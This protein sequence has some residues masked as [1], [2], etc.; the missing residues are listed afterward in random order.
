M[1]CGESS[2]LD[3]REQTYPK[4]MD[5]KDIYVSEN[6]GTNAV[7]YQTYV[8]LA[9]MDELLS[10]P[11]IVDEY[12]PYDVYSPRAESIKEG[13]NKYLWMPEKGYY[14]Q[15]LYGRH[16]LSLS[17][18]FEALGEALSVLFEVAEGEKAR[19]IIANSPLTTY[20]ATC[21]YP[22]IPGIPP[23]HNN[24]IWPFVQSYWNLAAAKVGNEQV[25][26]HGLASIYRAGAL[27]LTNYENFV[28][29]NGDHK[30][31]EINSHRMLWSMA[32]NI[33]MVHRVF[34]GMEFE[35]D[36]IRFHPVIPKA[37]TGVRTLSH[38]AY[39]QSDLTI[40]VR[41]HGN[42]VASFSLDGVGQEEAFFPA[43]L[44]GEHTVEIVMKNNDFSQDGIHLVSNHFT[45]PTPQ[46]RQNGAALTWAAIYGV[47]EYTIYKNGQPLAQTKA[48]LYDI[49][50][51]GMGQ[52]QVKAID[53]QGIESFL[54]APIWVLA[55]E[56]VL[57]IEMEKF[58]PKSRLPYMN[59][60]GKGFVEIAKG[61]NTEIEMTIK[62]PERGDYLL[63]IRYANGSGPWNTDNKCAIRSL[64]VDDDFAR[65]LVFPQRGTDEWS[66]WGYSN[67]LLVR[68]KK[69]KNRLK[70]VFEP[71]DENMN[72][73]VNRAM[74]DHVRL[75]RW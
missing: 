20:G 13:M 30:G 48:T 39:R 40:T 37:Y 69:G 7:H 52:F 43:G 27:F 10:V 44:T 49:S 46:V 71:W 3:W 16:Y 63:D 58:A 2:F 54:S 4:W 55:E 23:Y 74:L 8:I 36:G 45:L 42:E 59:F 41:G 32:G 70:L 60:S 28:A 61:E 9:K 22:Q 11:D 26:S 51:K 53:H 67:A 17:P 72:G 24:G 1:H 50:E 25:L 35:V 62:V 38:F 56:D 57:M 34:M 5:N 66:D 33:A 19:S 15:Y 64:Y 73:E 12:E 75:R 18:K 14:G 6:L 21:V 31:T 29:E 47:K 68:L 65:T